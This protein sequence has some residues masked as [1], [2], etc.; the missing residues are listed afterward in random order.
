VKPGDV[1]KDG[2]IQ[3]VVCATLNDVHT[4]VTIP[5]FIVD[6]VTK[7]SEL[8][9]VWPLGVFTIFTKDGVTICVYGHDENHRLSV[10]RNTMELLDD[11]LPPIGEDVWK[12]WKQ[13]RDTSELVLTANYES[14]KKATDAQLC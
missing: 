11:V 10:R 5:K 3:F 7:A 14:L 12:M 2:P 4:F 1:L 8:T 6:D 9:P 13:L